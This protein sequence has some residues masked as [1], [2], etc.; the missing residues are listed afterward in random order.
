MGQRDFLEILA[1]EEGIF[2]RR[3]ERARWQSC[4]YM[5][6]ERGSGNVADTDFYVTIKNAL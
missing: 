5:H 2:L 4:V 3:G 6:A 1:Q